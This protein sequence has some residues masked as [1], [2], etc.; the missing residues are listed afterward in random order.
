MWICGCS[1]RAFIV[2]PCETV[3]YCGH[4]YALCFLMIITS[5]PAFYAI[6]SFHSAFSRRGTFSKKY[7][8]HFYAR[9][10]YIRCEYKLHYVTNR[11]T[12][13]CCWWRHSWTGT[14]GSDRA[15]IWAETVGS[16]PMGK[17]LKLD[18]P[19]FLELKNKFVV[20]TRMI[21]LPDVWE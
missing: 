6:L 14:G 17:W 13:Q 21:I 20:L 2:S 15:G 18:V 7:S 3:S 12:L 10:V 19:A 16:C 8:P 5:C 9:K 1:C 4:G 11:L